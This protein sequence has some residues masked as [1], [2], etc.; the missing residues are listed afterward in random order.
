VHASSKE[1]TL[2]IAAHL[3]VFTLI[4]GFLL[5]FFQP[6]YLLLNTIVAGGDTPSHYAAADY[7][8]N[9]LLP[10]GKVMGW[11]QGNYAGYPL[12]QFY[13]P[14]PFLLTALLQLV[15]PLEIAF[16][17]V[18]V[19]GAFLLPL[20]TYGCLKLLG[21][22]TM[23]RLSGAAFTLPFLFMES[24][25]MWGGNIPST[26][27]GEFAYSLGF[28]LLVFYIG[29][30]YRGIREERF[31]IINALILTCIGLSHGYTLLFAVLAPGFFFFTTQGFLKNLGYYLKV[32]A[33]AFFLLGF[34]LIQLLWFMPYTTAYNLV[35]ILDGI[36]Q[37]FPRILLPVIILALAGTIL[38]GEAALSRKKTLFTAETK[39]FGYLWF[40]I[41]TAGALYAIAYEINLVDIRFLPFLQ[42]FLLIVGAIG[43]GVLTHRMKTRQL[44]PIFL[45]FLTIYWVDLHITYI[46]RW[47]TWDYAGI[48]TKALW[49][50]FQAVNAH[51]KGS[52]QDPRVVY[53]HGPHHRAAGSVRAFE[54]LPLFSGRSTL[55]GLYIQSSITSPFI[56]YLQSETSPTP[57]CPLSR[58]NYSRMNFDRGLE[59]LKLFNVSHF[60]A[61]TDTVREAIEKQ[62][63][64]I[65]EKDVPPYTVYRLLG[66]QDRY[67]S[68]L[69]HAPPLVITDN[70]RDIA[71]EW[72]RRGDL[73][74]HLVFKDALK[75]GD[76][77]LFSSIVHDQLPESVKLD[78][79]N[80]INARNAS[81]Q[82]PPIHQNTGIREIIG[83]EE[84]IIQ[85]PH[86]GRPHLVRISY[87]PNWHVEGAERIYLASPSFMLIYPKQETV[88]LYFGPSLPNYLGY[89]LSAIGLFIVLGGIRP[90]RAT[91]LI[92]YLISVMRNSISKGIEAPLISRLIHVHHKRRLLWGI[93]LALI[94]ILIFTILE[95]HRHD[96]TQIYNRGM[97][98]FN[99]G[100]FEKARTIFKKGMTS[101]PLSP[102]VDQ[103]AFHYAVT[104]YK[105]QNW[106]KALESF[107]QMARDYPETRKLPEVLYHIGLCHL[108]LERPENAV[109][110]FRNLIEDFPEDIWAE[111]AKEQLQ[112]MGFLVD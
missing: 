104:Y 102:I 107:E 108:K 34:W 42:F 50:Q 45:V 90:F 94:S 82:K 37:V 32:N 101:F 73:T 86:I 21:Q 40:T 28:A 47:I 112:E 106:A 61:V 11:M 18:T 72:F 58:Y 85:T 105:E 109:R 35:W 59:H 2:D 12:F 38:A 53:E 62:P 66:N 57:S 81:N 8:I 96:A 83:P 69:D 33:L 64:V 84:I 39:V 92:R 63:G 98:H 55:E 44:I 25:S 67:V 78:L 110:I 93:S 17:A 31:V 46:P 26:L 74:T 43:I 10:G 71:F 22:A 4:Y 1:K 75:P 79:H 89:S 68:L 88:R 20:C 80:S 49:P 95:V 7:L 9:T 13:F 111:Y 52:C 48:E 27:A 100:E 30:F 19:L 29:S 65:R 16:K 24:N 60:I 23:V 5:S 41:L 76:A 91:G 51:L 77:E 56:F 97:K 6:S 87:H 99:S 70:W 103:T 15:V 3:V 54:S 36:S 14:L